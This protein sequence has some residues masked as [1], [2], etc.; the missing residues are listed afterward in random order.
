MM[1]MRLA[2]PKLLVDING[3]RK[4]AYIR[5]QDSGVAIGALTRHRAVERSDLVRTACPLLYEAAPLIG[6]TAIRNRG[7]VGGSL[8]HADPAAELPAVAV[9]LDA[10]IV[11]QG[12]R[13]ER[14]IRAGDFFLG[15]YTTALESAELLI[16]V[17]FPSWP[18]RAGWAFLE[19]SRRHGDFAL[20]GVAVRLGL[21]A[22]AHCQDARIVLFSLAE[23]PLRAPEAEE[24]LA[25][26]PLNESLFQAAARQLA[27]K[28]EPP[29]D[30]HASA[31][32]RRY[33]AQVLTVR[34]L[35]QA[36]E[37]AQSAARKDPSRDQ[38]A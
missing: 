6:H 20:A 23:A 38:E 12:A 9:A 26:E 27:A 1:A 14:R 31:E 21:D 34:A 3:I 18:P 15:Y 33:V 32:Y 22:S 36:L 35:R 30:V 25:G 19:I 16:E 2:R 10:E 24:M 4:L 28:L 29:E 11:T 7:T 13:G 37:R 17:R 8:A 5:Q